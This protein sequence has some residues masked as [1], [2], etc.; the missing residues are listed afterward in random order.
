MEEVN[1]EVSN[2]FVEEKKQKK[3]ILIPSIL[4]GIAVIIL[5]IGGILMFL[6]K[7]VLLQSIGNMAVGIQNVLNSS[8]ENEL[9]KKL[10]S[11]DKLTFKGI[12]SLESQLGNYAINYSYADDK[13]A[14][15]NMIDLGLLIDNQEL[16]GGN[17]VTSNDKMYFKLKRFMDFYYYTSYDYKSY[18]D[19][20]STNDVDYSKIMKVVSDNLKKN[21][22]QKDIVS[23]NVTINVGG[24][25]KK[26]TKLTYTLTNE[27]LSNIILPILEDFKKDDIL[28][29]LVKINSSTKEEMVKSLDSIIESIKSSNS[30]KSDKILDYSVY[31]KGFNTI[32]RYEISADDGTFSY[33][34]DGNNSQINY[35]AGE[36]KAD[37]KIEK[38]NNKYNISGEITS[39]GT[40]STLEGYFEKD[41]DNSKFNIK[42]NND[43]GN[44]VVE[45]DMKTTEDAKSKATLKVS[46]N[47]Q[48][49]LKLNLTNEISFDATIDDSTIANSKDYAQ[50]TEEEMAI[51]QNRILSD[52]YIATII[53]QLTG[54]AGNIQPAM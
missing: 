23:D 11:S 50:I 8:S 12:L 19:L 7:T 15:K 10:I 41:N 14:K 52:P 38:N 51:I 32:L 24:K 3:K 46:M 35:S 5:I 26:V 45:G 31:Y 44:I 25:D 42:I 54:S 39:N 30:N 27:R 9:A 4:G 16:I 36:D 13:T 1:N 22:P 18:A 48:E 28:A 17:V 53:G 37:I 47:D 21:V 40:S 6:S 20:I 43:S 49:L 29:E 2:E 33:S 34:V